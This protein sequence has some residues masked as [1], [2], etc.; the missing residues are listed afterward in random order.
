MRVAVFG[1]SFDP[2]H[3]GHDMIVKKALS[4]LDIELLFITPTWLNPF[5]QGFFAPPK[6][7]LKWV[8]ALWQDLEKVQICE[9]ELDS[10]RPTPTIETINYLYANFPIKKCFLI[11][12]AD[13]LQS[14][15]K[16][17]NYEE[18]RKK[19]EIV[20]ALRDGIKIPQSLKK[21]QI[22]A[23]ISSSKLRENLDFKSISPKILG[24]VREFYKENNE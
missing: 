11:V 14:L 7:R 5:K 3:I 22:N 4:S 16:W 8:K 19:V 24:S 15:E 12:G 10:K 20:V 17:Q 6:Q 9:F 18:L 2:P 23:N 21:L 13:N 1:G